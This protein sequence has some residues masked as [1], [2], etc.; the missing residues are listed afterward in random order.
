MHRIGQKNPF[1]RGNGL[2]N[3]VGVLCGPNKPSLLKAW[4][5][6]DPEVVRP[7]EL[8]SPSPPPLIRIVNDFAMEQTPSVTARPLKLNAPE[9]PSTENNRRNIPGGNFRQNRNNSLNSSRPVAANPP[10]IKRRRVKLAGEVD[11]HGDRTPTAGFDG[12]AIVSMSAPMSQQR[13]GRINRLDQR[14]ERL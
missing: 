12:R 7:P 6:V 8:L 2:K 14:S 3:I 5:L 4:R 9:V 1:S 10:T 11:E 13:D